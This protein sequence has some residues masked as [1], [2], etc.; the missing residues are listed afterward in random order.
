LAKDS[1]PIPG[2]KL[3]TTCQEEFPGPGYVIGQAPEPIPAQAPEPIPGQAPE[4]ITAQAPSAPNGPADQ[5][6]AATLQSCDGTVEVPRPHTPALPTEETVL[7]RPPSV[8]PAPAPPAIL[9]DL[10]PEMDVQRNE[11]YRQPPPDGWSECASP[12]QETPRSDKAS[13]LAAN[14]IDSTIQLVKDDVSGSEFLLEQSRS[15]QRSEGAP[16]AVAPK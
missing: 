1:E 5:V 2:Q 9:P 16:A 3:P 8:T 12:F 15:P 4:L 13:E 11:S 7:P 14:L 6:P 10:M